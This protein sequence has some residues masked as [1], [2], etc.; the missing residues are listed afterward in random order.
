MLIK[1]KK[2]EKIDNIKLLDKTKKIYILQH[3]GLG[4]FLSCKGLLKYLLEN[5]KLEVRELNLFVPENHYENIKF[6]YEDSKNINLIKTKN[7][8]SAIKYFKSKKK[9]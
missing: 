9:N 5:K 2:N 1:I 4:D 3:F 8:K 6:L 7:E